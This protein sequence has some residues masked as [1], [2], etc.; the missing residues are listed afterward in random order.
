M[1]PV[2]FVFG[3]GEELMARP[4]CVDS[5]LK[6]YNESSIYDQTAYEAA[7]DGFESLILALA[8]AGVDLSTPQ[9]RAAVHTAY[10]AI[11]ENH[12]Q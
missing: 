12:A 3:P 6:N 11:C 1:K 2:I 8:S 7:I 5:T 10:E 4:G 9:M